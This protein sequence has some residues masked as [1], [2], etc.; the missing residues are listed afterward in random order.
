MLYHYFMSD[1]SELLDIVDKN[2]N[3]IGKDS[4][5]NKFKKEFITR[6]VAI[7]ILD[8]D[9]KLL[10]T[11]RSSKKISF[12]NRYDLA[13]CGNV[14]SGETYHEA[15]KREVNEELGIDCKVE[16]L[17]KI[18]NKFKENGKNI[19]YF[20]AIFLGKYSGKVILNDELV[21]LKKLT[22]SQIDSLIK[23]NKN[24]F[25]PGFINDYRQVKDQL[26]NA[27]H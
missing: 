12:P 3:V 16:L 25:T 2:D 1:S 22:L 5:E 21:E 17:N 6:N 4:K 26:I 10:I 27:S 19:K 8:N 15:V 18:Y 14:K 13:A 7:F 24:E 23:K 9:N 11:K 20:T